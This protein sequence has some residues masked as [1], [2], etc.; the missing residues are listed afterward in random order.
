MTMGMSTPTITHCCRLTED[1]A[2]AAAAVVVVDNVDA[3]NTAACSNG[4]LLLVWG[5]GGRVGG[6]NEVIWNIDVHIGIFSIFTTGIRDTEDEIRM[7]WGALIVGGWVLD[8]P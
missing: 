4:L 5:G 2:A 1:A 8:F 7:G 6:C 3:D